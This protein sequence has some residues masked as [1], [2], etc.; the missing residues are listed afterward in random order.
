LNLEPSTTRLG[1]FI[2]LTAKVD[3]AIILAK[4]IP[5]SL[6][7][8]SVCNHCAVPL[9]EGAGV[10]PSCGS[11]P[12]GPARAPVVCA[13]RFS[14]GGDIEGIGGWL[15]LVA[16][17]LVISPLYSIHGINTSLRIMYGIQYQDWLSTHAG[18][19]GL[20]LYEG[21]TNTVF[22]IALIALN[23]LFYRR[24]RQ[25]PWLMIAF[26]VMQLA[27][28]IIDH[29]AALHFFPHHSAISLLQSFVYTAVWIPY[30]LVSERVKV[31][32]VR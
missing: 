4:P 9:Q 10:C 30:Y 7:M 1:G 5:P 20:I 2:L 21:V 27:L 3:S 17:G 6:A 22:L 23:T 25:F 26:L 14:T 8:S 16:I 18:L 12:A 31:T 15:I 32:F 13:P 24:K 28:R 19:A 29:V 11:N